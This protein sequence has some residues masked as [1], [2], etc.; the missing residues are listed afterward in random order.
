MDRI[1]IPPIFDSEEKTQR[2]SIFYR[3][4]IAQTVVFTIAMLGVMVAQP[5]LAVGTATN[6]ALIALVGVVLLG[7]CRR[8]WVTAAS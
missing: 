1:F 8:G 2:A 4:A 7:A 6:A 3:V 5:T